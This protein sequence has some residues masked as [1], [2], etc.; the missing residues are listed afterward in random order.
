LRQPLPLPLPPPPPPPPTA[1]DQ[2]L[3]YVLNI[4]CYLN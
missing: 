1:T 3:S 2:H 4:S